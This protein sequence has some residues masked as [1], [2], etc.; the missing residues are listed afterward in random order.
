MVYDFFTNRTGQENVLNHHATKWKHQNKATTKRFKKNKYLTF[1]IKFCYFMTWHPRAVRTNDLQFIL[2]VQILPVATGKRKMENDLN[3][4]LK[5]GCEL[6]IKDSK[7]LFTKRT[8]CLISFRESVFLL[9]KGR[10][11]LWKS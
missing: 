3:H 2:T 1:K 4:F 8:H 11:D 9:F 10:S 5:L 7:E 6:F